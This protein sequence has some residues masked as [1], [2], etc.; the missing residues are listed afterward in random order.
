MKK[1]STVNTNFHMN[2]FLSNP[3]RKMNLPPSA[4]VSF[5]SIPRPHTTASGKPKP[6]QKPAVLP[7]LHPGT[8]AA[9]KTNKK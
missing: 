1:K 9:D 2:S 6:N 8:P 7:P 3:D 4:F 5:G